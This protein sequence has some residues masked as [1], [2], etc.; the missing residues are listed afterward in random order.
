MI[1]LPYFR[2]SLHNLGNTQ[3]FIYLFFNTEREVMDIFVVVDFKIYYSLKNFR[4]DAYWSD[5]SLRERSEDV[6]C[7][8]VKMLD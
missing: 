2:D 3:P 5:F 7:D 1:S 8:L 4:C 6:R